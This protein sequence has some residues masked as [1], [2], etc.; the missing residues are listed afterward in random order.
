MKRLDGVVLIDKPE[1][2][3]SHDVVRDVRKILNVR[4]VGHAGTLDPMATGL[5][6]VG[7]G[8]G[9]RLIQFLMAGNKTYRARIR[10]GAVTDT[11]DA[12]GT[13][14]EEKDWNSVN[15]AAVMKEVQKMVGVQ[16]QLPPMFSA[17]KTG[18]T[19]LYRLA[20]QGLDVE[21]EARIIHVLKADLLGIQLPYVDLVIE[22]SKGTYIRTLAHDFGMR[23]GCGAHLAG[24]RRVASGSFRVEES[25]TLEEL[26]ASVMEK[27][28]IKSFLGLRDALRETPQLEVETDAARRLE[29]GVPPTLPAISGEFPPREGDTVALVSDGRL[30]AVA[31]YQPTRSV[32]N[33]GDF[34][35]L[36]VFP[37]NRAA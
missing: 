35:L 6:V 36:R 10:L 33:R 17:L 37:Q 31:R 13:I 27:R 26:K 22:C 32:E 20:R 28:E 14:L 1:G 8:Q 7:I 11:Q 16:D 5:L 4:R 9:T 18:G 12:M 25:I 30:L 19:P 3:T 34:E 29:D 24:L 23:L 15:E 2:I 21:R